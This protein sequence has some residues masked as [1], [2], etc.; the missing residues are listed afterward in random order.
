LTLTYHQGADNIEGISG[1]M[2]RMSKM[3]HKDYEGQIDELSKRDLTDYFKSFLFSKDKDGYILDGW[4]YQIK[5]SF[6]GKFLLPSS[7]FARDWKAIN[8]IAPGEL[9][10]DQVSKWG[11]SQDSSAN[12]FVDEFIKQ[13]SN[14]KKDEQFPTGMPKE[15]LVAQLY[16]TITELQKVK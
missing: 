1:W 13:A 16:N 12:K 10:E 14:L 11:K 2:A 6:N 7:S 4:L 3:N 15:K 9:I 8:N 5:N